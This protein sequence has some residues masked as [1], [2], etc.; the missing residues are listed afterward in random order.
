MFYHKLI[1][2]D[3]LICQFVI[4]NLAWDLGLGSENIYTH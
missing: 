4:T 1:K 2:L 3:V